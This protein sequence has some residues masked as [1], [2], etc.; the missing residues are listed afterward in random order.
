MENRSDEQFITDLRSAL[1]YLYDPN[2][3]RRSP[4]SVLFNVSGRVDSAAALQ[5]ILI[6]AIESLH[7][8]DDELPQSRAWHIYDTL[9]FRYVRGADSSA[10]ANQ[11]GISDRQFRREQRTA[12]DTL[13]M[14]L[15]NQFNLGNSQP[16]QGSTIDIPPST[17]Q[18]SLPSA[19]I[20][21]LKTLPID[22]YCSVRHV[23]PTIFDLC[24]P[25]A[26]QAGVNLVLPPDDSLPDTL[27]PTHLL[28][29]SFLNLVGILIPRAAGGEVNVSVA[30]ASNLVKVSIAGT[31]SIPRPALLSEKEKASLD[32]AQKLATAGRGSIV[33]EVGIL[34]IQAE[35]DLP[36]VEQVPVLVIDDNRDVVQLYQRYASGSRYTIIGIHDPTLAV[37]QAIQTRPKVILLDLMMPEVDGWEVL[38]RL[39]QEPRT[40]LIPTVICTI[41]PQ[42]ALAHSLGASGFLQ[43][44]VMPED[45]LLTLDRLTGCKDPNNN[46]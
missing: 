46:Y 8:D 26:D 34:S 11:L 10:V 7:P 23:L 28:R 2:Q 33:I 42:E 4:L 25:L 45:F 3:L 43:K 40:S 13:A 15:W 12:I 20:E 5:K 21:W 44:P 38:T 35:L 6:E 16:D 29:H 30:A 1:H 27:A 37:N 41:L 9:F 31:G 22:K 36:V 14:K 18:E 19:D 39:K 32:M 24:R 17:S